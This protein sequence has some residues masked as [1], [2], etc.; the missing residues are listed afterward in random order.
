MKFTLTIDDDA[1]FD[2]VFTAAG[3]LR[4]IVASAAGRVHDFPAVGDSGEIADTRGR[5]VGRWE[6]TS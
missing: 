4:M 6:V 2:N 1:T 3:E 5:V